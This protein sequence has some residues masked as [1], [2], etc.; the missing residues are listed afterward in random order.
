MSSAKDRV[1]RIL[2]ESGVAKINFSLGCLHI[3]SAAYD[4]VA[5]A[6][7]SGKITVMRGHDRT[8]ATYFPE[9]GSIKGPHGKSEPV[10]AHTLV[11][12]NTDAFD[13]NDRSLIVHECTHAFLDITR[14][15]TVTQLSNELAGYFAQVLYLMA[16]GK[17]PSDRDLSQLG[18]M[19]S[20][21][22]NRIVEFDL[23]KLKGRG[24]VLQWTDYYDLRD[25]IHDVPRYSHIQSTDLAFAPGH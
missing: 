22:A 2:K 10:A 25:M 4:K 24:K 19:M 9:A 1:L 12:Q 18:Q 3:D 15:P 20:A 21:V 13:V 7:E 6:I 17:E 23:H 11:T 16:S 14:P 8:W 5:Q